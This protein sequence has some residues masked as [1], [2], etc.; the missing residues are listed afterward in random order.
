M[1]KVGDEAAETGKG[2]DHGGR[3]GLPDQTMNWNFI[4]KIP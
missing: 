3:E 1:A 4:L 2:L